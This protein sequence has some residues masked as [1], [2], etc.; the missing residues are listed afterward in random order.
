M[1]ECEWH[2]GLIFK[3]IQKIARRPKQTVESFVSTGK[4][5]SALR[6]MLT[7]TP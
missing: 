1:F 3:L 5:L 6:Q 2:K 4:T 7:G